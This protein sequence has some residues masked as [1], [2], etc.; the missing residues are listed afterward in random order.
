M[1]ASPK[2]V[3]A[4]KV[5]EAAS[6][7]PTPNRAV[8]TLNAKRAS[9]GFVTSPTLRQTASALLQAPPHLNERYASRGRA[10]PRVF[11]S[12]V[13][14]RNPMATDPRLTVIVLCD[15]FLPG[16]QAGGVLRTVANMLALLGAEFRFRVITRGRDFESEPYPD[17]ETRKWLRRSESEVLYLSDDQLRPWIIRR[18]LNDTPHDTLFLNSVVSLH[19]GMTPT[20]LRWLNLIPRNAFIVAP[21]GEL[22]ESALQIKRKRKSLLLVIARLLGFYRDAT[23]RASDSREAADIRREFGSG[24]RIMIAENLPTPVSPATSSERRQKQ[25]GHLELIYLAR[26]ARIKNLTHALEALRKVRGEVRFDLYGPKD[27]PDYW[28]ECEAVVET[29]PDNIRVEWKG[30]LPSEEVFGVLG[31]YDVFVMPSMNESFG[32]SIAEALGAGC[33]VL[34]SDCTPWRDLETRGVGWDV[35][36]NDVA[37]FT[38][39]FQNCIDMDEGAHSTLREAARAYGLELSRPAEVLGHYHDLIRG[40]ESLQS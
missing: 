29:L 33:P 15:Y 32:Y 19:F 2:G 40:E 3:G 25:A 13:R 28:I 27:D 4:G 36:L 31:R 24:A 7:R 21:N 5:L 34:I 9:T 1:A 8:S 20:L 26:L 17:I 12:K 37:D 6:N 10:A 22:A 23:W 30:S 35:P 18:L 11:C 16:Y 39:V 14:P 38:Q